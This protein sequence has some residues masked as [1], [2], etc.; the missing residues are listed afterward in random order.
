MPRFKPYDT[1][2]NL[3]LPI[4][5]AEQ[6]VPGSFE[7]TLNY[8]VDHEIDTSI[9]HDHYHNDE[10]GRLAYDPAMLL[11][12]V[13]F[14][15]SRGITSSRRIA[16][17]CHENVVF[18]ALSADS[19]PHFTTIADFISRMHKPVGQ[20]FIQVLMICD[21]LGLIGKDMFAIDGRK[22]SSNA[23]K[24]WSGT[25]SELKG[26]K[27]KLEKAVSRLLKRHRE[28]DVHEQVNPQHQRDDEQRIETLKKASRRI[29]TFL[30]EQ[31][32]RTNKRKQ[33]LKGNVTDPDSA[34]MK[35]AKGVIQG[36]CGVAAVDSK[37]QVIM[38]GEAYGHGAEQSTLIPTVKAIDAQCRWLG[39]SNIFKTARITAD[40]GFH[41]REN[42]EALSRLNVDAYI[43]DNQ[44]RQRDPDFDQAGRFRVQHKKERVALARKRGRTVA[45]GR[46]TTRDFRFDTRTMACSC[47][48]GKPMWLSSAKAMIGGQPA[49]QFCGYVHHCRDCPMK[50][51]CLR[52]SDQKRPR[53]VAFFYKEVVDQQKPDVLQIMKDKIDSPAGK[54]VYSKRLAVAEP[55]FAHMQAM[56]LSELTLRGR[57]K[58][59]GQWQLMCALHNLKKI[60]GFGGEKLQQRMQKV[61]K[62]G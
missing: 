8:L 25:H 6:L 30:K 1:R 12:I 39:H 54:R 37:H 35:T 36:Y 44:Y 60:H 22:M 41:S 16:K 45:T 32:E 19:Q 57:P 52:R 28:H 40:S 4:N 27:K 61:Q 29:K 3:L 55:P 2:Q 21:Q 9:F 5:L 11:K 51:Q 49:Y 24:E 50:A 53:S 48:A 33:P 23:S 34:K 47:P 42:L 58:V 13:L 18:M 17:A 56:G 26:K 62:H 14:A 7:Y 20:L 31:P 10:T 43:A 46:F 59:N 38:H 15:Y